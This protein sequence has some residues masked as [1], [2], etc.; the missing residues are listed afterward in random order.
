MLQYV[1][2]WAWSTREN[3]LP[4][5]HGRFCCH[6]S[7]KWMSL[8][9]TDQN[10]KMEDVFLAVCIWMPGECLQTLCW[11]TVYWDV[12]I[13][14]RCIIV[15]P[16][17]LVHNSHVCISSQAFIFYVFLFTDSLCCWLGIPEPQSVWPLLTM[18]LCARGTRQ[19]F[20]LLFSPSIQFMLVFLS[21]ICTIDIKMIN[22]ASNLPHIVALCMAWLTCQTFCVAFWF[23]GSTVWVA[24][25]EGT[26]QSLLHEEF[27]YSW[28]SLYRDQCMKE[29]TKQPL[30]LRSIT[31]FLLNCLYPKIPPKKTNLTV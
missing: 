12:N 10:A 17:I 26:N 22:C 29:P 31:F 13:T 28:F 21:F 23:F 7:K 14:W 4:G 19:I 16:L 3:D 9:Q 2:E 6:Y 20:D 18:L 5:S 27:W 1:K 8:R 11:A 30:C 25:A 24:Q 15:T